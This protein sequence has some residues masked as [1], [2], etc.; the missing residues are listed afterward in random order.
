[1]A[2]DLSAPPPPRHPAARQART[3]K[4]PS[5]TAAREEAANGIFQLVGFGLIVT[6]QYADAGAINMH[7]APIAHELASLSEQN[8]GIA[9]GLDYLLEAG[10]YAG[11]ITAVMPL[12]LQLMANHGIVKAEMVAGGGVVPPESLTAEVKATMARQAAQAIQR[13]AQAEAELRDMV[14]AQAAQD[15]SQSQPE[16]NGQAATMGATRQ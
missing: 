11:L 4:A 7:G 6:R 2:L 1:M 14:A 16:V 3:P 5:K 15:G 10:P 9:K 13:Q 12:A 8:D